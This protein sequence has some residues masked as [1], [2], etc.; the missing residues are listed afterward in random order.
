MHLFMVEGT[1]LYG[2]SRVLVFT[3]N[4]RWKYSVLISF[5]VLQVSL[6]TTGIKGVLRVARGSHSVRRGSSS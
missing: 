3:S 1:V 6:V 2:T 5:N 4:G